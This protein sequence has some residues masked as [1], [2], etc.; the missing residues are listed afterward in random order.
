MNSKE[1]NCKE[2][3]GMV[4]KVH[5]WLRKEELKFAPNQ[6]LKLQELTKKFYC[7]ELCLNV[8]EILKLQELNW[9]FYREELC[10]D[11][12]ENNGQREPNESVGKNMIK[13]RNPSNERNEVI[14]SK[15]ILITSN[16]PKDVPEEEV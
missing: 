14:L 5:D 13:E 1:K 6:I 9:N 12:P 4:V 15:T 2:N 3:K 7:E 8:P 10:G 16:L 11:V